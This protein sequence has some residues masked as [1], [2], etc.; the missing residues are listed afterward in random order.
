MWRG[1]VSAD[2]CRVQKTESKHLKAGV[3]GSF[4]THSMG[5]R[6]QTWSSTR[7]PSNLY[8]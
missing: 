1:Y 7:S 3:T 5:A 2:A 4:K 8:N 6:T